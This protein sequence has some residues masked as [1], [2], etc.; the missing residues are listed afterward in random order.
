MKSH[1]GTSAVHQPDAATSAAGRNELTNRPIVGI[2]PDEHQADED[3]VERRSGRPGDGPGRLG[4][5]RSARRRHDRRGLR[6]ERRH[7]IASCSRKRRMLTAMNG[8]IATSRT[9]GDR[10]GPAEVLAVVNI[11][12]IHLA[13]R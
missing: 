8:T 6:V 13:G 11:S 1:G 10:A 4:P 9:I 2:E 5:T 3:D 12:L 7:R